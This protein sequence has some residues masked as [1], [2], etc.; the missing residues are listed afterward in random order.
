MSNVIRLSVI[1]QRGNTHVDVEAYITPD[2]ARW[3][4]TQLNHSADYIDTNGGCRHC[5]KAI[6]FDR[7]YNGDGV[8]TAE[9]LVHIEFVTPYHDAEG[10]ANP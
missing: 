7:E 10:K 6:E 5:G 4:A 1:D 9:S 2:E 8:I 3:I